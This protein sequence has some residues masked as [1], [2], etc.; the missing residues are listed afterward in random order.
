MDTSGTIRKVNLAYA[1]WLISFIL[2]P[3]AVL[4][5]CMIVS[6]TV[7]MGE[8]QL[9]ALIAGSFLFAFLWYCVGGWLIQKRTAQKTGSQLMELKR[10]GFTAGYTFNSSCVVMIDEEQRKIALQFG[11]NPYQCYLRPAEQITDVWVDEGRRGIWFM[12]G[13][14]KVSVVFVIDGVKVKIP[15]F[16]SLQRYSMDSNEV[17]TGICKADVLCEALNKVRKQVV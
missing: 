1:T 3:I 16:Y 12:Q 15:V 7:E 6:F 2:I 13:S 4:L 11:F 17:L 5:A 14:R 10:S 8:K 9:I